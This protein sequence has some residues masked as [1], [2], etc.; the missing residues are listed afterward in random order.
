MTGCHAPLP[1]IQP[2]K[3][4]TTSSPLPFSR[5]RHETSRDAICNALGTVTPPLSDGIIVTPRIRPDNMAILH[6]GRLGRNGVGTHVAHA[7]T[8]AS[9]GIHA[10]IESRNSPGTV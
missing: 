8:A 3:Y 5:N 6:L 2:C 1:D 10:A 9:S 4:T 7:R